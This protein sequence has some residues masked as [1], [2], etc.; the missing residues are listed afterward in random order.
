MECGWMARMASKRFAVE[1]FSLPLST[2]WRNALFM[3]GWLSSLRW[4]SVEGQNVDM[5]LDIHWLV[6]SPVA[7]LRSS[8]R[9]FPMTDQLSTTTCLVCF[10]FSIESMI[11]H[12]TEKHAPST[13]GISQ[14]RSTMVILVISMYWI[15]DDDAR[16]SARSFHTFQWTKN[17]SPSCDW[18]RL[19][20]RRC[21]NDLR[22]WTVWGKLKSGSIV[23]AFSDADVRR[24]RALQHESTI[25]GMAS[26]RM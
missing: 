1:A 14:E 13:V 26:L 8:P 9:D 11:L 18:R 20:D 5:Q 17:P 15:V 10:I 25:P 4:S 21:V 7:L 12:S 3:M 16:I 2:T 19:S 24:S 23:S 22:V 6:I